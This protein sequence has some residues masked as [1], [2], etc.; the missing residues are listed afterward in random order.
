MAAA[1][2]K[3]TLDLDHAAGDWP[4]ATDWAALAGAAIEAA[5]RRAGLALKS[6]AAVSILL[7][8]DAMIRTMNR[9][10]RTKDAPTNVLSFQIAAPDRLSRAPALGDIVLAAETVRR[11]AREQG[12]S[13]EAHATHLIVHGFLHLLGFD[14]EE[15]AQAERMEALETVILADL[16]IADPYAEAVE[17][18]ARPA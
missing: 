9:D 8:D 16:G 10:W 14:H 2:H 15:E 1:M 6:G 4:A 13:L 7:T 12:V 3:L 11:E 17:P 18:V 5:A